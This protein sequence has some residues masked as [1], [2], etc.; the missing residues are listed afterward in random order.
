MHPKIKILVIQKKRIG[1]VLTSTVIF[2]ALKEKY[3]D[4]ELHYLINKNAMAVVK[5]NPFIDHFVIVEQNTIKNKIA[6]VKFLFSIREEK[7]DIVIDSYSKLIS[8]LMSLFSGAKKR[9][10]FRKTISKYFYTHPIKRNKN[11]F[12]I[13]TKAVE[14]RLILLKPLGIEFTPIKPKIYLTESEKNIAKNELINAKLDIE[15][16]IVMVSALGSDETKTYPLKYMAKVI[17]LIAEEKYVQ[18]L[19]NYLP[20]Q[21]EIAQSIFNLCKDETKEKIC[22]DFYKTDL[23]E[24]LAV[25]SQCCALI[26][27]EGGAT[28]MAKAIEIPTFTIFSPTI[29]KNDW[30]MFEN[31]T[32]NISVH[33]DDYKIKIIAKNDREKYTTFTPDLFQEKLKTFLI[34]NVK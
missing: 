6:F 16:P 34:F 21:K 5:N 17:D 22:L 31:E 2:E 19:L 25:T 8:L 32:T 20:F 14:H 26:G 33:P 30:N 29:P 4:S 1:D 27:N 23:R 18:I 12:S 9:I 10:T 28:N 13:A 11:S 3:P 24:F 15:K 7:Y